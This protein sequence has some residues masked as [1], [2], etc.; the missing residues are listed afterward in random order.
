MIRIEF[1]F[2]HAHPNLQQ[3]PFVPG[4]QAG[5]VSSLLGLW[6]SASHAVLRD[7]TFRGCPV[8]VWQKEEPCQLKIL[9]TTCLVPVFSKTN[10]IRYILS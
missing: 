2:C 4:I 3:Y 6:C 8:Y 10:S 1:G 9:V 5:W 7:V